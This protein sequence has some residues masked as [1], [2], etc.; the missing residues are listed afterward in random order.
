MAE[1]G[2]PSAPSAWI[3]RSAPLVPPGGPVLDLACGGGRHTRPF[4][5]RGHP[6][7]AADLDVGPVRAL[8]RR[9]GL[10]IV[11][12]DLEGGAP[13][14]LPGRRFAG[15]V[16]TDDLRRP[17]FP[18]LLGALA[19]GGVLPYETFGAGH[20]VYGRPRRPGF[21]LAPGE[22]LEAVRGRLRVVADEHGYLAA[23]GPAVR[24]RLGATSA[25][26][27]VSLAPLGPVLKP[28]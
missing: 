28:R 8:G 13:W 5:D 18:D 2:A 23:P 11:R 24:Q 7:T 17:L 16:V 19:P 15:V 14:P 12:A 25:A 20:A 3:V 27:P 9:A 22:L 6:V 1:P 21:L 26:G 4:L 10:E